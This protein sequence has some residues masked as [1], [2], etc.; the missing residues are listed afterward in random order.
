[1]AVQDPTTNYKWALPDIGGNIGSWGTLLNLVFG[2]EGTI[3]D[4]TDP[5]GIDGVIGQ[6]Q[7]DLDA[8]ETQLDGFEDRLDTVEATGTTPLYFQVQR[9]SA[10]SI[11]YNTPTKVAWNTEVFDE[12]G[13]HA[14]GTVTLATGQDGLWHFNA[15]I[16]GA[17]EGGGDD[18]TG[19][20][21]EIRRNGVAIASARVPALNDGSSAGNITVSCSTIVSA[22]VGDTF[23]VFVTQFEIGSGPTARNLASGI[24]SYFEGVRLASGS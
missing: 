16:S 4:V 13:V 21:V 6:L 18:S 20:L 17:S 10:Q 24:G 22:V 7:L 1:M 14:S 19:W 8:A 12:G 9:G 23:E 3:A 11:P 5:M 2:N 15:N